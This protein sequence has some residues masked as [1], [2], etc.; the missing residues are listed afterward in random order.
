MDTITE[1]L[2]ELARHKDIVV[3]L[4]DT[5]TPFAEEHP[6]KTIHCGTTEPDGIAK[7]LALEGKTPI[8]ITKN[9]IKIITSINS[10]TTTITPADT[11]QLKKAIISASTIKGQ[12]HIKTEHAKPTKEKTPLTP[13]KADILRKGKDCT[14]IAGGEALKEALIAA[15]KLAG[16][17]I[18]CTVL[19]SHTTP[20]DKHAI[21]NSARITGCIVDASDAQVSEILSQHYPVPIKKSEPKTENI[22]RAVKQAIQQRKKEQTIHEDLQFKLH[23][24]ENIKNLPELHKALI[25]MN[26]ETFKHHCNEHKNDFS[27]WM[28]EVLK[29][30]TLSKQIE[31][32]KKD[33]IIQTIARWLQ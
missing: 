21:I 6:E 32:T 12:T 25:T 2:K 10:E 4:Q 5:T 8:I 28:R 11:A 23:N 16:H 22:I 3:I 20:A 33:E 1:A 13:G 19:N 26:E 7:G 31:T 30:T 9:T 17:D 27:T 14:I 24:G 18:Q 29:E 15:D